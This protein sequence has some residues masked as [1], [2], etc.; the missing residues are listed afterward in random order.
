MLAAV[1]ISSW[2]IFQKNGFVRSSLP[3]V[4]N[5]MGINEAVKLFLSTYGFA[6]GHDLYLS[7][8][9]KQITS[10]YERQKSSIGQFILYML[11][12]MIFAVPFILNA[13]VPLAFILGIIFVFIGSVSVG[14]VG[15]LFSK[16]KWRFRLNSGGFCICLL[17]SVLNITVGGLFAPMVGNWYPEKYEKTVSFKKDL[18]LNSIFIWMF[19]ILLRAGILF[20]KDVVLLS[21]ISNISAILLMLRCIPL[22]PIHSYGAGRVIEWNKAMYGILVIVSL[23]FLYVIPQFIVY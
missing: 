23:F 6:I 8:P 17:I 11:T 10:Q 16:R 13:D 2:S 14:Y 3:K 7:V 18:A 20:S 21:Y 12:G 5:L 15:T 4:I 22:H 19:L 9:D 1:S